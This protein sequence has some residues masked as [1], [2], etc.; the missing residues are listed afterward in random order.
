MTRAEWLDYFETVNGRK[1]SVA[2][3]AE[4]LKNGEFTTTEIS[5]A[6]PMSAEPIKVEAELIEVGAPSSQPSPVAVGE[7]PVQGLP[8]LGLTKK[9]KKVI[10]LSVLAAVLVILLGSGGFVGYRY[11]SGNI[12]GKWYSN[13]LGKD[14]ISSMAS[15]LKEADDVVDGDIKD[16]FKNAS[17]SM[18]VTNDTAKV[19]ASYTFDKESFIKDYRDQV[20]ERYSGREALFE[21]IFGQSIDDY[22]SEE[23][24]ESYIDDQL[25]TVADDTHQEYDARTGK[26]SVTLFKGKVDRLGHKMRVTDVDDGANLD[27]LDLDEGQELEV[28]KGDKKVTLSG[29]GLS[30]SMTFST[31]NDTEEKF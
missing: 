6:S 30:E 7:V 4:A 22:F 15:S 8:Q 19:S 11:L 10:L 1:P 9:K 26:T 17:V 25:K 13:T 18:K 28:N 2:E 23:R 14:Y 5:D 31:Q 27:G 16:Y 3:M 21:M 24:V 12:D 20:K 29:K